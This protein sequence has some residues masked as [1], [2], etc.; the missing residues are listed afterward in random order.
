[1]NDGQKHIYSHVKLMQLI[2]LL[3]IALF[4]YGCGGRGS[5]PVYEPR[6]QSY[7]QP[8]EPEIQVVPPSVERISGPAE[9]L[10]RKAKSQLS[11]KQYKQAELTIERA[12]RVEP[13]NGYYWYTLAEIASS[14]NQNGRAVQF[15][16]KSKSFAAGDTRLLQLN[17]QLIA[18]SR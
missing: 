18:K 17:D 10:Y 9:P 12:L 6:K 15:C 8:V 1:M 3:F 11:Q 13:K 16:L 5:I 2:L 4:L 14:Q 7:P